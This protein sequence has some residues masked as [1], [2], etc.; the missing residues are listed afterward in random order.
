MHVC[1]YTHIHTESVF[2]KNGVSGKVHVLIGACIMQQNLV[3]PAH[4]DR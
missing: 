4:H 3:H 2:I 1:T